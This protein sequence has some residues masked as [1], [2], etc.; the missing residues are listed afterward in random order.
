LKILL[1][2]NTDWYLYN[3]R[4][5]LA[6]KL[7]DDGN[8][9]VLISPP[10]SYSNILAEQGFDWR[11]FPLSRRGV[12]PLKEAGTAIHLAKLYRQ[13][14][15]D[16]AHHFTIK[17]V[18]YGS[19]AARMAKV[20]H[21]VNAITGR[22][23]I[24][25]HRSLAAFAARLLLTPLFRTAL[26]G[27]AVVFQNETDRQYFLERNI[28]E[29]N[30]ARVILGSGV[31]LKRFQFMPIP[32]GKPV[33][34][35]PARMLWS[36]GAGDFVAAANLASKAGLEARFVLAGEPDPGSP[37]SIPKQQ[38][39]DWNLLENVEWW[40][41]QDDMADVY[42]QATVICLPS[43]YGE[44]LAKILIEGAACGRPLIA[45]DIPGC[46]EVIA[47]GENGFLV[48]V[49]NPQAL[50]EKIKI[51]VYNKDLASRMGKCGREIAAQKFSS[52]IILKQTLNLYK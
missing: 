31:D 39:E 30:Q 3:Y 33:I 38:L 11:P 19:L 35:L 15:P 47:E 8:E 6:Q 10:G 1:F 2:A 36:K 49:R 14:S 50:F 26:K 9:V 40:G 4:I 32:F 18:L 12:N 21:V 44:G 5:D 20:P 27:S 37:D 7:I 43:Y 41:W 22:G 52:Q 34:L 16:A 46:R 48:P 51:L 28:V 24:Y 23:Y 13:I 29:A 45:T 17:C 25:S 42:R